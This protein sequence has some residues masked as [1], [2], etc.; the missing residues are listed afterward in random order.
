MTT[1]VIDFKLEKG[2]AEL[3]SWLKRVWNELAP[4]YSAQ[5]YT[6]EEIANAIARGVETVLREHY[7]SPELTITIQ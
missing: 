1:K 5:G 7:N 2:K 4:K 6:R 3:R